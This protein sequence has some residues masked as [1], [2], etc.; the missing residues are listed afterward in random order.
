MLIHAMAQYFVVSLRANRD[1]FESF[2][3]FAVRARARHHRPRRIKRKPQEI[4]K[5]RHIASR[6]ENQLR[7][8]GCEFLGDTGHEVPLGTFNESVF[9]T[10]TSIMKIPEELV[11]SRDL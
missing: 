5:F 1:L 4:S 7:I 9:A 2:P 6:R 8:L 11:I 10:I 3:A